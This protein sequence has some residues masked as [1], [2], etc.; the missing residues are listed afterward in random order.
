MFKA[1]GVLALDSLRV[2]YHLFGCR[3]ASSTS[4]PEPA[5]RLRK[6]KHESSNELETYQHEHPVSYRTETHPIESQIP[7]P[8]EHRTKSLEETQETQ[9]KLN[10]RYNLINLRP[11]E[12]GPATEALPSLRSSPTSASRSDGARAQSAE[13]AYPNVLDVGCTD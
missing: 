3:H 6:L 2:A 12:V 7:K 5:H 13:A 4:A 10:K 9:R 1:P 11:I 8:V